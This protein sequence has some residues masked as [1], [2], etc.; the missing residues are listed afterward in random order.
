[1]SAKSQ[2]ET[3]SPASLSKYALTY[4]HDR[5]S[6][7]QCSADEYTS[8]CNSAHAPDSEYITSNSRGLL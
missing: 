8:R 5:K 2:G 7:T 6:E 3:E 4:F 1:M